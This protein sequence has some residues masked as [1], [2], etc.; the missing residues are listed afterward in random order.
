MIGTGIRFPFMVKG[1]KT[2]LCG[3]H[4]SCGDHICLKKEIRDNEGSSIERNSLVI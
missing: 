2:C 1:G 3:I 4:D